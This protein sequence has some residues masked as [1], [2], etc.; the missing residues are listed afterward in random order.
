M[1]NPLLV[2]A[3]RLVCVEPNPRPRASRRLSEEERWRVVHLSTELHLNPTAIAKR[4]GVH[5]H[6]VSA[7]L[8]KYHET[9]TIRDRPRSGRKR[10]ISTE[11][12]KKIVK[13]AKQGKDAIEIAREYER[14]TKIKVD[15]TTIGRLIHDHKL[16]WLIRQQVQELT[17]ANKAKRLAYARAMSKYNW[18][19]VLFSDEKTFYLG[20]MKTHAY[21]EPGK[22]KTFP[23]QR[24]PPKINVW[25]GAGAYMKT[26]LYFFKENMDAPLYRK[27]LKAR[28]REDRI[29]F[30]PDCP[31]RLPL[32]SEFLQDNA[33]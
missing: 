5:R 8:S 1:K 25:A 7:I 15:R 4:L 23:V 28:L 21:Q 11:D 24:H 29:T 22:R 10:K 9:K 32:K 18:K 13:K 16:K 2:P 26:K 33:P 30:A 19:R 12:E 31:V 14:E 27:V 20:A 6:T 3:P 17:A